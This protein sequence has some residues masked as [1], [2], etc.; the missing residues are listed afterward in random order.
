MPGDG[1]KIMVFINGMKHELPGA[2]I[3]PP[4]QTQ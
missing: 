4:G 3:A 2:S 1:V